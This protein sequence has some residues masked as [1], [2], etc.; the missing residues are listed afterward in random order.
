MLE[1]PAF[2]GTPRFVGSKGKVQTVLSWPTLVD[3]A[4]LVA[5]FDHVDRLHCCFETIIWRLLDLLILGPHYMGLHYRLFS[6]RRR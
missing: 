6:N 4:A 3:A 1:I 2:L 5:D